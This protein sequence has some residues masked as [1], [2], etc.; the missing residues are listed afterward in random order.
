MKI[1]MWWIFNSSWV[2]IYHLSGLILHITKLQFTLLYY[3]SAPSIFISLPNPT[4]SKIHSDIIF[5]SRT[6]Y[7][8]LRSAS[9]LYPLKIFW[10][11]NESKFQESKQFHLGTWGFEAWNQHILHFWFSQTGFSQRLLTCLWHRRIYSRLMELYNEDV[12]KKQQTQVLNW[13]PSILSPS[14]HW[15]RC[16]YAHKTSW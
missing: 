8:K 6:L 2:M 14:P 13:V 5:L 1:D 10:S 12:F 7:E 9:E 11:H 4:W 15:F 3:Q 16:K